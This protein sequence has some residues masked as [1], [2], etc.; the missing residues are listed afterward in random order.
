M[1]RS[2]EAPHPRINLHLI[3]N[4]DKAWLQQNPPIPRPE[5]LLFLLKG[6]VSLLPVALRLC[7]TDEKDRPI[8]REEG[9]KS[10]GVE[11]RS[12]LLASRAI[13]TDDADRLSVEL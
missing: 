2:R 12:L 9:G 3:P 7:I 5:L 1:C 4:P 11:S 13:Y 8:L 10:M 6:M